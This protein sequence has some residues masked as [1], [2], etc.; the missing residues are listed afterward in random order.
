MPFVA[1]AER[2]PGH[3]HVLLIT[4]GSVASIKAP[5]IVKELLSPELPPSQYG[6]VRVQ[7]AATKT[8]L[9]FYKKEEVE[10]VGSKVW[11]DEDEWTATYKIGDPILHIELRRWADVVLVA[12]CSANTLSKI[13]HG[14]C[15]NLVT[16]LMRALSPTTPTYIFPAMN[17]L[18]YEHPL[19]AEHLRIV[20]ELV[21]YNVVGPIGKTLACGDVGVGAMTEWKDIVQIVVDLFHLSPIEK[22]AN[23]I[24]S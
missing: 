17:T 19:T 3:T 18:M 5:L 8:S 1:E 15:D 11:T 2:R 23:A 7:V 10:D 4:S 24:N 6:D 12:P 14:S 20:K 13:A 22:P 21:R 16:S 9:A